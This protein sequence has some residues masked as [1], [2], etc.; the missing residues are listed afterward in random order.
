MIQ[1]KMK[2]RKKMRKLK[3]IV[4]KKN[5][6]T[7]GAKAFKGC[8]NLKEV[9]ILSKKLKKVGS[10]AFRGVSEKAVIKVPK[11]KKAKYR[12]M[13]KKAGCKALVK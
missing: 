3:K 1:K 7:I 8:G 5:V 11:A 13:L 2:K 9:R 6:R 10:K 4:I 12:Q